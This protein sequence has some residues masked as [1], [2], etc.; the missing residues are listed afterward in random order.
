MIP[1]FCKIKYDR[2]NSLTWQL[3]NGIPNNPAGKPATEQ[4]R[5]FN[6]SA[7]TLTW[8]TVEL[9]QVAEGQV[10]PSW[11]S[12][13][14]AAVYSGESVPYY[15]A[16]S[17]LHY[18]A[19]ENGVPLMCWCCQDADLH[20]G[21]VYSLSVWPQWAGPPNQEYL[22]RNMLMMIEFS[23][24]LLSRLDHSYARIGQFHKSHVCPVVRPILRSDLH[25]FSRK[26]DKWGPLSLQ[27]ST[28]SSS[29]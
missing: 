27:Q 8:V 10:A 6:S 25:P 13:G 5:R 4:E 15:F 24:R 19:S 2:L 21:K 18:I 20:L 17:V 9:L 11:T 28:L 12:R 22:R 23:R 29:W 26:I 1:F 3:I 7:H 16:C 14:N